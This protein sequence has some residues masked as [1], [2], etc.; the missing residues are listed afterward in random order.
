MPNNEC[1]M[2]GSDTHP[3]LKNKVL[4]IKHDN[5]MHEVSIND[6][7][8]TACPTCGSSFASP[9]YDYIVR[10]AL[11]THLELLTPAEIVS[12]RKELDL[13][14]KQLAGHTKI[15]TET[16]S[17]IE[18]NKCVQ[19]KSTDD[20]L[21]KTFDMLKSKQSISSIVSQYPKANQ[22]CQST[23]HTSEIAS[24]TSDFTDYEAVE[25]QYALAA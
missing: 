15:A 21:R 17:R 2:C 13:S 7:P 5:K 4:S 6:L 22:Y 12:L 25:S 23:V 18:N 20:H 8:T 16:I 1:I 24:N 11:R 14:A 10:D 3:V 9:E 19:S